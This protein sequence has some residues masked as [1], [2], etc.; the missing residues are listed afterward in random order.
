MHNL[1]L[2]HH[3]LD[4]LN[5]VSENKSRVLKSLLSVESIGVWEYDLN[6][7]SVSFC[8]TA[9]HIFKIEKNEI[10]LNDWF[11]ALSKQNAAVLKDFLAN[12][13]QKAFDNK[14]DLQ[15][16]SEK[17][18][19]I[20]A[21]P[22]FDP[23]NK[24]TELILGTVKI[25][26]KKS[27]I[28]EP[29]LKDVN[30]S[31]KAIALFDVDMSCLASSSKWLLMHE[32]KQ[33]NVVGKFCCN[34][35]QQKHKGFKRKFEKCLTGESINMENSVLTEEGLNKWL[36]IEMKPWY[37]SG[38]KI[39]G[40]VM[41]A[42]EITKTKNNSKSTE[43]VKL[44]P[45]PDND[46]FGVAIFSSKGNCIKV[47]K[48]LSDI[49]GYSQEEL[50]NL[51][52]SS[53]THPDDRHVTAQMIAQLK[54]SREDS[55]VREKRYV[56][57][58]GKIIHAHI[59]I[60]LKEIEGVP[61]HFIAHITDVTQKIKANKKIK[62][63]YAE[64]GAIFSA[65]SKVIIMVTDANGV[66][67]QFNTG[68]ENLLGYKKGEVI[69]IAKP[70]LFHCE[71]DFKNKSKLIS[72]S[73]NKKIEG[74]D[75]FTELAQSNKQTDEW[76]YQHKNGVC[77]PVQ[78][79]F[80]TIKDSENNI[81]G[82][83]GVGHD[84]SKIKNHE[85]KIQDILEVSKAQ[86]KRLLNFAHIVSHNLKSHSGNFSMLLDLFKDENE[87]FGNN[88]IIKM[89]NQAS[90][91]L[92][93]TISHL[94]EVVQLNTNSVINLVSVNLNQALSKVI[95]NVSAIAMTSKVTIENNTDK[96][97]EVLCMPA[98]LESILLN[99]LTNGIRYQ[100]NDRSSYVK[101]R[102]LVDNNWIVLEIEDNGLGIDLDR[103]RSKLFG[104]YKTFHNNKDSR[105]L[106]LFIAKNQIEA[107]GGKVEVTSKVNVGTVF[108]VYFKYEK[109]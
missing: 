29:L 84:I 50:K 99:F 66:I 7:Q 15:F 3:N 75:V 36:K 78:L 39:S 2:F 30:S 60:F 90:L 88:E 53:I 44:N 42:E 92:S 74:F 63:A 77:F 28:S 32:V 20:R 107:I 103:H 108:K 48:K 95:E 21:A 81:I 41:E 105:G 4:V 97:I 73:L 17:Y 33:K 106:G 37:T 19:H 40:V 9:S 26:N 57:K 87:D 56:T 94:N 101:F 65:S 62:L 100:S 23:L 58:D 11:S 76:I 83:L 80:D 64:M 35:L 45:K 54:S 16:S 14:L 31:S 51:Y 5:S 46:T 93:E 104:M 82:Y 52:F 109:N 8:D 70:T 13:N 55:C 38:G 98:Y 47:N 72:N 85:N 71:I 67:K 34:I 79:T 1:K 49:L 102:T 18:I 69:S 96:N 27:F 25:I 61:L 24:D 6:S 59:S 43:V 86:N 89:L 22:V 12:L 10:G 68:A 91:N